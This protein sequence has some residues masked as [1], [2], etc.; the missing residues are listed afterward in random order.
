MKIGELADATGTQIETI[1]YYEREGLLPSPG[2]SSGNYR[3]Y[4]DAHAQRLAFIRQCRA[5]D[6]TLNEIR[7]LLRFKDAPDEDCTA[8]NA[9]LDEHIAHVNTRLRELRALD[10]QLRALRDRCGVAKDAGSCGILH[11]LSK[12]AT[13]SSTGSASHVG[14]SHAASGRIGAAKTSGQR[15]STGWD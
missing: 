6:M 2:R 9:L 10:N 13:T 1:R 4:D 8:V 15:R 7:V 5:L 3:I 12:P 11:E 14:Q